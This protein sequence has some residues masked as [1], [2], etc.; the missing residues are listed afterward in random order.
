MHC[1]C[2]SGLAHTSAEFEPNRLFAIRA[3]TLGAATAGQWT[4]SEEG[5]GTRVRVAYTYDLPGGRIAEVITDKLLSETMKKSQARW[6][7][8]IKRLLE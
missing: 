2:N 7:D 8:N 1:R 5:D 4:L 6:L 3:K